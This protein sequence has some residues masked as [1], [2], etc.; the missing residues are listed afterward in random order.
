MSINRE[1]EKAGR[2]AP[3]RKPIAWILLRRKTGRQEYEV[4]GYPSPIRPGRAMK[5]CCA[6]Q[7]PSEQSESPVT[8][9]G[10]GHIDNDYRIRSAVHVVYSR[11]GRATAYANNNTCRIHNN[12]L[13]QCA[14]PF[15]PGFGSGNGIYPPEPAAPTTPSWRHRPTWQGYVDDEKSGTRRIIRLNRAFLITALSTVWWSNRILDVK[16]IL[17]RISASGNTSGQIFS[18]TEFV[19]S[20]L[21]RDFG[22]SWER[23]PGYWFILCR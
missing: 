11:R 12:R 9:Q 19:L 17:A 20:L 3:T 7:A 1:S 14:V 18:R 8:W 10:S 23:W 4:A 15:R 13:M 6:S 5:R 16:V 22:T 2:S 21:A